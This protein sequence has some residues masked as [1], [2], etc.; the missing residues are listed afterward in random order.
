MNQECATRRRGRA[1]PRSHGGWL[2]TALAVVVFASVSGCA[3]PSGS[4]PDVVKQGP[5][6]AFAEMRMRSL[7]NDMDFMR[8]RLSP[9][10]LKLAGVEPG[11]APSSE[12]VKGVMSRLQVCSAPWSCEPPNDATKVVL[13][14]AGLKQSTVRRFRVNLA[15]DEKHG[16]QLA[17]DLYDERPLDEKE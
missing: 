7:T 16:W 9:A 14:V 17:S 4:E 1:R 15:F 13:E 2:A 12:L 6:A 11:A 10:F 3:S 8:G 5:I